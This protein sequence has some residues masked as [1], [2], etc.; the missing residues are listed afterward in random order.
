MEVL[1]LSDPTPNDDDTE[2]FVDAYMKMKKDGHIKFS[3]K[4]NGRPLGN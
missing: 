4:K 3:Q 2:G 1:F